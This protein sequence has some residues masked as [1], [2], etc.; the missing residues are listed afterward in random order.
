MLWNNPTLLT[1]ELLK[2][3]LHIYIYIYNIYIHSIFG[4]M[5]C[6]S[7]IR[8]LFCSCT[9]SLHTHGSLYRCTWKV[10][11]R[12][13]PKVSSVRFVYILCISKLRTTYLS[14]KFSLPISRKSAVICRWSARNYR[15]K[16][17]I[18][19]KRT[20]SACQEQF[21]LCW[22]CKRLKSYGN[23]NTALLNVSDPFPL[24]FHSQRN[25]SADVRT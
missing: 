15:N 5:G 22:W 3:I 20:M 9:H 14:F 10:S 1:S 16:P 7:F 25:D 12:L 17:Y 24:F 11:L 13:P 4:T 8:T 19:E 2:T 18:A 21:E 6:H 23:M